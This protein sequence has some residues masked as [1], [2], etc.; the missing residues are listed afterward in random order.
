MARRTTP[1]KLVELYRLTLRRECVCE[2][3]P[4][5]ITDADQTERVL[6]TMLDGYDREA[7]VAISLDGR[8]RVIGAEIVSIGSLGSSIVHPREVFKAAIVAGAAALVVG[9][10]HPSGDPSPSTEDVR[11][12]ERLRRGGELLGIPLLDHV[13]I[14][15]P[16]R[17]YSFAESGW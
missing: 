17:R 4:A 9:H 11:I 8:N 1:T 10:N 6:R 16:G 15:D 14:G 7:F 2:A 12:T 3:S 5:R 13:I